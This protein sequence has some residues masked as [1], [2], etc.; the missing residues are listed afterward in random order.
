MRRRAEG[1]TAVFHNKKKERRARRK[2]LR[3]ET[4]ELAKE[5]KEREAVDKGDGKGQG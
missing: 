4:E 2:Q 1:K 3:R 5:R